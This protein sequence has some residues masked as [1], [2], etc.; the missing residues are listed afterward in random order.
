MKAKELKTKISHTHSPILSLCLGRCTWLQGYGQLTSLVCC[1]GFCAGDQFM[2]QERKYGIGPRVLSRYTSLSPNY[3]NMKYRSL[4]LIVYTRTHMNTRYHACGYDQ[5]KGTQALKIYSHADPQILSHCARVS[6]CV[7]LTM[8]LSLP[9]VVSVC[10]PFCGRLFHYGVSH[11]CLL[12]LPSRL[13]RVSLLPYA[14]VS[15]LSPPLPPSPL[16]LPKV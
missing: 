2:H 10:L 8:L 6:L 3:W 14:G 4:A 7:S 9:W 11:L 15:V 5:S 12:S 13:H 16:L 1:Q